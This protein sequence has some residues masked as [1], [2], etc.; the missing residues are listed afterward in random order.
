MQVM[1]SLWVLVAISVIW[2]NVA[3]CGI[4]Y[5]TSAEVRSARMEESLKT[6]ETTLDVHE[7]WGEPD[8]RT[9]LDND[10]QIWSY[11]ARPNS[12]DAAAALLYT[13]TKPGDTGQ[14]LDLK[15]VDG[16]LVSWDSVK[17]T[18][19]PKQGMGFNYG[20]GPTFGGGTPV[21]HY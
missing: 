11:V 5:D 21:T 13:S 18:V 14:F 10:T 19:P 20:L 3:A 16:K 12:N 9:T 15:F 17:H 2:V 1:R 6:G 8:I 7:R 4:V